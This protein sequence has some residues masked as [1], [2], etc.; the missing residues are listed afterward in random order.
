MKASGLGERARAEERQPPQLYIGATL[1]QML[2]KVYSKRE[3]YHSFLLIKSVE[4]A[5]VG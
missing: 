3:E 4:L 1:F 2:D 5:E